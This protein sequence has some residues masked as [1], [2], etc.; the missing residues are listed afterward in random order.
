MM[1][2]IRIGFLLLAIWTFASFS[3]LLAQID[4][5]TLLGSVKDTSGA[6]IPGA[7]V[8]I[9]NLGTGMTRSVVT[10][11]T[12]DFTLSNLR[13]GRYA[14]NV[15]LPGFKTVTIPDIELQ[16]AQKARMD[17]VLQ[18][19]ETS[20]EITVT[21]SAPL[22]LT[23]SSSVGQVV[24]TRVVEQMP[25]N[26]RNFWQLVQLT[27]GA[28]YIPG[29]QNFREGGSSIRSAVVNV[30]IN[31]TGRI[32]NGWS[33][34]GA[35]ITEFEQGGTLISPNVD[36]LQAFKLEGA[37]MSAEY[38]HTP[39]MV[40]ATLKSGSNDFHGT[41]F[42]FLRNDVLDARNFFFR[43][44]PGSNLKKDSLRR[45]QYG[46]TV[47]GPIRHDRTFFFA[48]YEGTR[49]RQGIV[50]N[51]VVPS[52]AMRN[53]DFSELL[54]GPRPI[55]IIDP[56]TKQPFP[57]NQIPANLISPQAKFFL[58]F[59]PEANLVQG[60]TS[61][62]IFANRLALD[63]EKAD[64]KIDEQLT[65]NDHL[66]GRYSIVDNREQDPNSF[67]KLGAF[68]L[69]SRAQ[70][71]ALAMTH[72]FNPRW[73]NEA[74]FGY[75]RSIF[76]FGQ[77]LAGTNF[78]KE[79]G[80][81]GF[82][83]TNILP[84][85][86]LINI[87]GFA[88]FRGSGFDNRPKSN[89]I[90]TWQYIDNLSYTR[91]KHDMKM[92]GEWYHQ[93][94][95]FIIG[96]GAEG[97]F[98][99]RNTYSGNAFADFLL[100]F[101]DNVFR[102][103]FQNLFGNWDDFKHFYFQDNYRATQNLTLNLGLRY[104]I[105]PFFHGIRAQTTGFDFSTGKIVI[106]NKL[107]MT[108]QPQIARLLPLFQDRLV[109][110]ADLGLPQTIRTS[111]RRDFAPRVGFAWR[112]WGSGKWVV[113]A[114]YG[115]FY[116]YPDT[117]MTLQWFKAPPFQEFQ[118]VFND[119]SP[120]APTRAWADFFK[121]AP[122]GQPNPN[123]G[124]PCPFGF[125]ANSCDTPDIQSGLLKVHQTYMQQWNLAVQRE[126]T[127]NIAVDLAYVGN[128]TVRLQQ[129]IDR[130]NPPPGPGAIQP[131][132]PFP[133]W[134]GMSIPEWIGNANYHAFQ[135]KVEGRQWHGLSL[136]GSYSYSKCIDTG[137]NEG[138]TAAELLR[139]NR[140]VCDFDR[141]QS[142]VASYVYSLPLGRGKHFLNAL[143]GWAD[144]MVGGWEIS[145]ITTFQS[146]LPFTATVS[147]DRANTGRGGQRPDTVGSVTYPRSV[148]CWFYTSA[149]PACR[150]LASDAQDAFVMPPAQ[151]R[152]GTTGRNTLRSDGLIQ[153]DFTLMKHFRV[154][155]SR[156][157][158][159]RSEFFNI[160][161]HPT[162][163]APSSS[164]NLSNGGQVGST[165]NAA[166][167]VQLALKFK[168]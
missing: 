113:R 139:N 14:L 132:R 77:A 17:V 96:G 33:L 149:N 69:S 40:N 138:G 119:R 129:F 167:I 107:D 92:G 50:F 46:F 154:T 97:K 126:I 79:A 82:D 131:R 105:N 65:H 75:Y 160:F 110:A 37:N 29:G 127:K 84:S 27:P 22:L 117:N 151:T 53:G 63:V 152:Y 55:Q 101:P 31:G 164:T 106:P 7:T 147:G 145:G 16:V 30:N 155:E 156:S 103:Y 58:P 116:V 61:R 76:I 121:G 83:E 89:R 115:I 11:D 134:G 13:V 1:T 25:L 150:A 120:A 67:P 108:A 38:G 26:G 100:G 158:E 98:T 2:R 28:S 24:D 39:N 87:D 93:T 54:K 12:G 161:N 135:M 18:V 148:D 15:N 95:G 81:Q 70:S 5:A 163:S 71:V 91:G 32:F 35:N 112:P 111:E 52:E 166:R 48:D 130:D 9:R 118:T 90:R 62:A 8:T 124:K 168:F 41:I 88:Q 141:P 78:T 142:L 73:L 85:F 114:G 43:P 64:L 66:M 23:D 143:S 165:L 159:F 104:E 122:L 144:Q 10:D 56:L 68:P 128:T 44:A 102:N 42:E 60:T 125:V 47:G 51:N 45:N 162:F 21:E 94:H 6:V 136:L 36:A 137:S 157:L 72:V 109:R 99:F 86:P 19:G 4:T 20:Q 133:Q 80:I 49:L 3:F 123:P 57:S 146:G 34:D 140:G 153:F 59:M 74:R